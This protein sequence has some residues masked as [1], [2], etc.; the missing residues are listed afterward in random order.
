MRWERR[1]AETAEGWGWGVVSPALGWCPSP[2]IPG[3]DHSLCEVGQDFP[4]SGLIHKLTR[5]TL[6]S[7]PALT[8]PKTLKVKLEEA[9]GLPSWYLQ[10]EARVRLSKED[11]KIVTVV[12]MH[13]LI[14]GVY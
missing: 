10:E 11:G 4:L 7:F 3:L 8:S 12:I 14:A 5:G 2:E 9:V 13:S 6:P 1:S